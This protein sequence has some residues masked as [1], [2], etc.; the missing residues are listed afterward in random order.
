MKKKIVKKIIPVK[1]KDELKQEIKEEI[2]DEIKEEIIPEKIIAPPPIIET[3]LEQIKT[4]D[5]TSML[6]DLMSETDKDNEPENENESDEYKNDFSSDE[7]PNESYTENPQSKVNDLGD[8]LTDTLQNEG[9]DWQNPTDF[10]KMCAV[11][12]MMYVEAGSI[13]LSFIG[14]LISGDWSVE[15]ENKYMP[16]EE[17]R[18]LIRSPLAKKFELNKNKNPKTPL[19]ALITAIL[20]TIIPIV[21]IAFK[22][23]K[24]RKELEIMNIENIKLRNDLQNANSLL[25]NKTTEIKKVAGKRGRHK[26]DCQCDKC[27]LK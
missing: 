5:S 22:D 16:S 26:K 12:A 13:L 25:K 18:K 19:S 7:T 11:N 1:I 8:K 17:R 14:Q 3:P 20:F 4:M 2:I 6:D 24:K 15:G 23:R 10:K 27:L 9:N 21:L